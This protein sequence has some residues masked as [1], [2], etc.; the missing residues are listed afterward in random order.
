MRT[1]P[2]RLP[3]ITLA[4]ILQM[5]LKLHSQ[6]YIYTQTQLTFMRHMNHYLFTHAKNVEHGQGRM[7]FYFWT[8]ID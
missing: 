5:P 6:L 8:N 4:A 2:P 1:F 3:T 7:S